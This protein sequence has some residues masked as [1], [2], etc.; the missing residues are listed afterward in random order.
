V[1]LSAIGS[2]TGGS[3]RNPASYNGI[4]GFKPSFGLVSRYGLVPL[5]NS[6]D[7]PSFFT[8]KPAICLK[9][10]G[11]LYLFYLIFIT[12]E[13]TLG[14]DP[15]DCTSLDAPEPQKDDKLTVND[16]HRIKIGIPR[17]F[18]QADQ[19]EDC[20]NIWKDAVTVLKQNGAKIELISLPHTKYTV[21]CYYILNEIDVFSNMARLV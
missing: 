7:A 9:Y 18:I 1:I 12:L 14:R 6:F 17:E 4:V 5:A 11:G 3:A 10:F 19:S 8:R 20:K 2:D 16:L 13:Y 21:E 15:N